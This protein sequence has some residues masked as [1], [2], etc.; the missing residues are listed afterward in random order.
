MK[1]GAVSQKLKRIQSKH[2]RK[3]CLSDDLE[4][5]GNLLFYEISWENHKPRNS[6][7]NKKQT[8]TNITPALPFDVLENFGSFH[9]HVGKV[10][11]N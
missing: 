6:P 9:K 2:V 3:L 7:N 4:M 10:M 5:I 11:D 8:K 1:F